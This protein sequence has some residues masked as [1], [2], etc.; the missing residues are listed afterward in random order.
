MSD[1]ELVPSDRAFLTAK[2]RDLIMLNYEVDPALLLPHVPPGTQLD[3]WSDRTFV[4]LVGFLFL[5]TRILGVPIPFHCN[6][7]EV[8]LRFYVRREAQGEVRRGVVFIREVVPRFAIAAVARAFYNE[9]YV[10]L[11]MS[12]TM[13]SGDNGRTVEY[14]W[15]AKGGQNR[16]SLTTCGEPLLPAA[17]SEEQ[18]ITEHY[19]GYARQR[20]GGCVEYRVEH[21]AWRVWQAKSGGFE[22]DMRLYYGN[23]LAS[24][25]SRH[26]NSAFLAEGSA[27][28]VYRGK[29]IGGGDAG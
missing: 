16:M 7:E 19:W 3:T 2:W 22:G 1:G 5:D 17:D 10:A 27:V 29:R 28:K 15:K 12:H 13:E 11:R 14:G 24:V 23:E 26:P 6:F 9:N 25:L 8:N 21:P 20:D 4:S 18:F